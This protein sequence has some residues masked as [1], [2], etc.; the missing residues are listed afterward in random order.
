MLVKVGL[1]SECLF[2]I[3]ET[4]H[5]RALL[6]VNSEMIKKVV[7]F[8]KEHS[9]SCMLTLE[10]FY[11]TLGL[12]VLVLVNLKFPSARNF[13]VN[14][15]ACWI[16]IRPADNLNTAHANRDLRFNFLVG[17]FIPGN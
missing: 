11:K 12:R 16:E 10:Y 13:L 14:F 3:W 15:Q 1:L 2:A 8:S 6:S 17:D 9:T 4:A 5:K 7:P